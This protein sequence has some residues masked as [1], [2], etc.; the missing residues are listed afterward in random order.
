[1]DVTH[2]TWSN[3]L[4]P[5][6]SGVST[7]LLLISECGHPLVHHY[8]LFTKYIS[9]VSLQGNYLDTLRTFITQSEISPSSIIYDCRPV[10]L[11]VSIRLTDLVRDVVAVLVDLPSVIAPPGEEDVLQ[12]GPTSTR[13]SE[14][15]VMSELSSDTDPDVECVSGTDP[16]GV[17]T[18]NTQ[19]V[20]DLR[21]VSRHVLIRPGD[22][23]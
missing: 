16:G 23:C 15:A 7:D 13:D 22:S 1:M 12:A 9:H 8:R 6:I 10:I 18:G 11:P 17:L 2:Q 19:C 14:P 20:P 21:S 3:V 4:S 5:R